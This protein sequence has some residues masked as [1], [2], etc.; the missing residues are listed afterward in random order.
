M[1]SN[2]IA[3]AKAKFNQDFLKSTIEKISSK[4]NFKVNIMKIE[5]LHSKEPRRD[6]SKLDLLVKRNILLFLNASDKF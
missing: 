3:L 5:D 6:L 1:K 2:Y 4:I